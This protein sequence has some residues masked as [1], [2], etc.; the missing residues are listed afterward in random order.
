MK[1]ITSIA[2][3]CFAFVAFNAPTAFAA[4][5]EKS[6]AAAQAELNKEVLSKPFST[7]EYQSVEIYISDRHT[8]GLRPANTWRRDVDC[9]E[10]TEISE[11]RDCQYYKRYYAK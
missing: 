5:A 1:A 9:E 10:L 3:S 11:Y 4:P 6:L 2:L 8:R 7:E